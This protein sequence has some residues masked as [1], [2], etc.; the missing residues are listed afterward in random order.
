MEVPVEV[1]QERT[2]DMTTGT[3]A[4]TTLHRH[5]GAASIFHSL[6]PDDVHQPLGILGQ[7]SYPANSPQ[8]FPTTEVPVAVPVAVPVEVPVEVPDRWGLL[9]RHQQL[10]QQRVRSNWMLGHGHNS[11]NSS[12][13]GG[14]S[15]DK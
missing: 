13:S 9:R 6:A 1:P 12:S 11:N 8:S 2:A 15:S 4:S 3:A 5:G 10:L 7:L 14:S